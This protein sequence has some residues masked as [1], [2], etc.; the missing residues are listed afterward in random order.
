V[1][2]DDMTLMHLARRGYGSLWEMQQLDTPEVLDLVEFEN[3]QVDI[4]DYLM[5]EAQHG[6]SK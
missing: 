4:E 3:I 1:D 2:E 5:W 6:N